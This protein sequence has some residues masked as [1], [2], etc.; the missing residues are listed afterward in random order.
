MKKIEFR[1]PIPIEMEPKILFNFFRSLIVTNL[2]TTNHP[3]P[4]IIIKTPTKNKGMRTI[5][6]I[7]LKGCNRGS[8]KA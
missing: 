3:I 5:P 1:V 6:L 4:Y 2:S 8:N 7:S